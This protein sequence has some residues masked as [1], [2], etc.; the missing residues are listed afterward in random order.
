[1]VYNPDL[2]ASKKHI[3]GISV[4]D[5]TST[6]LDTIQ[7]KFGNG[8]NLISPYPREQL[9]IHDKR[10]W[11]QYS[12]ADMKRAMPDTDALIVVDS[13]SAEDGSIWYIDR[14]ATDEEVEEGQ[15][16][17]IN[18]LFKLRMKLEAVVI[19]LVALQRS[20]I[21]KHRLTLPD[22]KTTQSPIPAS[23]RTWK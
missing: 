14:F 23:M 22:T 19:S 1:M 5:L 21:Y 3:T 11:S 10:E 9:F 2:T 13:R 12:H 18:T 7:E 8:A 16:E 6:Q 4:A 20:N 15:A 17:N